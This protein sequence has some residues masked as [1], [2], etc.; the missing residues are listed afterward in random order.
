MDGRQH[1]GGPLFWVVVV[2]VFSFLVILFINMYTAHSQSTAA[3]P[4]STAGASGAKLGWAAQADSLDPVGGG[5]HC[6]SIARRWPSLCAMTRSQRRSISHVALFW[7]SKSAI[8]GFAL[9]MQLEAG[10]GAWRCWAPRVVARAVR[11]AALPAWGDARRGQDRRQRR[12]LFLTRRRAS[13][14]RR[15]CAL[16]FTKLSALSQHDGG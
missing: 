3:R 15:K 14:C 10:E 2:I 7:I 4:V 6:V 8:R 11:C 12:D 9:D 16:L 13:T 5:V 1:V